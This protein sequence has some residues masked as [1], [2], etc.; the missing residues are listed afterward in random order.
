ILNAANEVAVSGFLE[1]RIKFTDIA[2][3]VEKSLGNIDSV[4]ADNIDLILEADQLT[5]EY[6]RQLIGE[7]AA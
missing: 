7:F 6:S 5:R 2:N 4:N 3:V 1:G